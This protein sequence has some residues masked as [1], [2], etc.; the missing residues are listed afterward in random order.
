MTGR[1]DEE[2][3]RYRSLDMDHPDDPIDES[4]QTSLVHM[5]DFSDDSSPPTP[6]FMQDQSSYKYWKWV[7]VRVRK[8]CKAAVRWAKGPD[9]PQMYIIT[10]LLPIVQEL[11]IRLLD[12]YLPKKRH[13][14]VLLITFYFCWILTFALVLRDSTFATEIEGWGAPGN[15]GCG[16][17]YWV[18][19]NRCG[20]NGNDCRPFSGSGF[21]FRCPANC[22]SQKVWNIRAVGAQEIIRRQ[23]VIGGPS[24][25]DK[26]P[27]YRAD[28]FICGSAIHAGIIDNAK[29][30]CG[31]VSLVGEHSNYQSSDRHGIVSV[32]FDS[33]FPSSFTFHTATSCEAKDARWSL[34]FVSLTYTIVLSLFAT[35]P[36]L[37]FF[38]IFTGLFAHVGLASDPPYH[39]SMTGLISDILGRFL[40]AAF[41]AFV[42]YRYMGV[43]RALTGLTAQIEKTILWL[44][45]CWVGALSNY[46]FEFIPIQRL[47]A[48]DIRKQP[49]AKLALTLIILFLVLVVVKQA[50]FFQRE[51]RLIRYLGVYGI[52]LG[53]ILFTLILPG[54]SLRIHHY[55]LA[56]LLLPGTSMQTRP[57]LLYQGLLVGL[58]INGIARWGFDSVLQTPAA[59]QGDAPHNSALPTI[60]QPTIVLAENTSTISFS[61]LVPPEPFDGISVLV[62]D[63]ERFRG[64]TDEGFASDKRFTKL[65]IWDDMMWIS[66][67]LEAAAES[68]AEDRLQ[69]R[70]I[71]KNLESVHLEEDQWIH[72]YL[73]IHGNT[74]YSLAKLLANAK[75]DGPWIFRSDYSSS[76]STSDEN[77]KLGFGVES[78]QPIE[79]TPLNQEDTKPTI[80][81][82]K[83]EIRE[84]LPRDLNPG[85]AGLLPGRGDSQ[86]SSLKHEY[87]LQGI[88]RHIRIEATNDSFTRSRRAYPG[89]GHEWSDFKLRIMDD[90]AICVQ[91]MRF[92]FTI[93]YSSS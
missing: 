37:F 7:P 26:T 56:L 8:V 21:A 80:I 35:S 28:S 87:R 33:T 67:D 72:E 73:T 34:L 2:R 49:G 38:S 91:I 92:G 23:F 3:G 4:T 78:I 22:A 1:N 13:R 5:D 18:P 55:I 10:P 47:N 82:P 59:L 32:G 58:F 46:T 16:N 19:G 11:P 17:T 30:G 20:L 79:E 42:I 50:F 36:G 89:N 40:P 74:K 39:T 12:Q 76:P 27:I 84:A 65:M 75:H 66:N 64:Y 43:R 9:P 24:D 25:D 69:V 48:D 6:R 31:V 52:F 62:N 68:R 54:L 61:W 15:I 93:I 86:N 53:A 83:N 90:T 14:I 70:Q 41:C 88:S 44:G 71:L 45:G 85:I 57:A 60:S 81:D 77:L 29:G 51:G 63:V